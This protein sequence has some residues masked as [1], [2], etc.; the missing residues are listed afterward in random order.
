MLD[1]LRRGAQTWV[2]KIFF[3]LLV[4]SFGVWGVSRSL[5]AS[6]PDAV[7]TVGDQKVG[8]H[9]FRLAYER[10][11]AG[12]SRQ[13][14]QRITPDQARAFGIES[15][16]YGQLA[17]GAALDQLSIKMNLG[18]SEARLAEEIAKE[19]AFRAANGKFD[20]QVFAA[21]LRNAGFTEA[22]YIQSQTKV[23]I[24]S[25]LVDAIADGFKAPKTLTDAMAQYRAQTRDIKYILLS[26]SNVDAVKPPADDVLA[27]WYDAH[28]GAYRAPEYRKFTYMKLEPADIL[29]AATVSDADVKADYEKNKARYTTPGSRSIELLPFPDRTA[30]EKADQRLKSGEITFDKFIEETGRKPADVMLGNF[31][32]SKVPDPKIADAAFAIPNDGGVSGVVDGAFGP[33]ILRVTNIKPDSQ[34]PFEQVKDKIRRDM[35][36]AQA[37]QDIMNVRDRYEDLRASGASLEEAAKQLKLSSI[38][39]E[40][41]DASGKDM[42]GEPV[43]DLPAQQKLLGEV[44]K[45]E[46]GVDALPISIGQ[47]GYVWF[48]VKDVIAAR[49]RKLEEVRDRVLADWTTEQTQ[50][51]LDAKADAILKDIKDGKALSDIATGLGVNLEDK[52]G[53]KR[54]TEDAVLSQQAISAAFGGAEGH[55]AAA[56]TADKSEKIVLQVTATG[57][58]T[59]AD[60]LAD[61]NRQIEQLAN[62]AGDDMLDEMV[63][64]L[65]GQY[66]VAVNQA[67]AQQAMAR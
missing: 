6:T 40:A 25:Q 28:K 32:K 22:D 64:K 49:D 21:T 7:I 67:L 20:R 61:D 45:T 66:G 46:Q 30:A 63:T 33:V 35:A 48:D 34:A 36:L 37:A 12:I 51:E 19:P 14:G 18:L 9:E 10:Q 42:K 44:F 55:A 53:I 52:S 27:K 2:A 17:A 38:T 56:W 57:T 23:A 11:I 41:V 62:S 4:G 50:K 15:Q 65:Q 26:S 60:P 39:V 54:N 13:L 16:V 5:V 31:E 3:V 29:D 59:N 1:L 47:D 24:R 43:K 8:T 58:D